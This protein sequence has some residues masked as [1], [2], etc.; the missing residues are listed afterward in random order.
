MGV[1]L[2]LCVVVTLSQNVVLCFLESSWVW[3]RLFHSLPQYRWNFLNPSTHPRLDW[4]IRWFNAVFVSSSTAWKLNEKTAQ[5]TYVVTWPDLTSVLHMVDWFE[6]ISS[7][8][9]V[10]AGIILFWIRFFILSCLF[11]LPLRLHNK[12][13]KFNVERDKRI[14]FQVFSIQKI[15]DM[16]SLN[17]YLSL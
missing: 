4:K 14:L 11:G 7:W 12:V 2:P 15:T 8:D 13:F 17:H 9:L 1:E 6:N 16:L 5:T 10:L 3:D